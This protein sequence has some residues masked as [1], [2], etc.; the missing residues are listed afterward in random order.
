MIISAYS[1]RLKKFGGID[2]ETR[3]V[4]I[5]YE[6]SNVIATFSAE[7]ILPI[8]YEAI[9]FFSGINYQAIK[10]DACTDI[11][12]LL[13]D[14]QFYN[15]GASILNRICVCSNNLWGVYD[16][17]SKKLIMPCSYTKAIHYKDNNI[18]LY[19]SNGN[20]TKI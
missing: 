2:S 1:P 19:D 12:D 8:N 7:C 4:V 6:Y 10:Y 13:F 11:S 3:K 17:S 16:S 15:I 5:P 18:I 20:K 9:L 14:T